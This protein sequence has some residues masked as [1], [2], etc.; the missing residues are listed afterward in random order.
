[1]SYPIAVKNG[2]GN[3]GIA[4]PSNDKQTANKARSQNINHTALGYRH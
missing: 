1:M 3:T 4:T 2:V